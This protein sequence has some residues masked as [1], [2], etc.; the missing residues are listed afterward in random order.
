MDYFDKYKY[1][2]MKTMIP[3]TDNNVDNNVDNKSIIDNT[4]SQIIG[5]TMVPLP[6]LPIQL[7][8]QPQ[9]NSNN[10]NLLVYLLCIICLI[11][12]I[13]IGIISMKKV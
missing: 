5:G 8:Y 1:Q 13:I 10:S 3:S 2:D 12:I 11:I 6:T 7:F 9:T 4:A